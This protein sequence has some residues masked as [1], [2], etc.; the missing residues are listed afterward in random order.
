[1]KKI[2]SIMMVLVLSLALTA[3]GG[4]EQ[5][6]TYTM[7]TESDGLKMTDTM[8]LNAK[9]DK[10]QNMTE[11][12]ALDLT[13][14]DEATQAALVEVYGAIIDQY[15]SVEGVECSA[16]SG[17]GSYTI[18]ISIDATG[19]AVSQL[20]DMGLL[21][22]EGNADTLSLSA[23]GDALEASGYSLAEY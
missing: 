23:T 13:G 10:V 8:T 14:F 2:V 17:E 4:K 7:E 5:S 22:V 19:D 18:T 6:V 12:I 16:E 21:Q 15:N 1:M 3:C 20:A 9:G 11:V